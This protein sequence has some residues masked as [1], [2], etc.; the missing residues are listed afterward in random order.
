MKGRAFSARREEREGGGEE[1]CEK[2]QVLLKIQDIIPR[3]ENFFEGGPKNQIRT[4]CMCAIFCLQF[5][6]PFCG[7]S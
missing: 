1:I 5:L 3:D 2:F 6:I 4:F 7:E